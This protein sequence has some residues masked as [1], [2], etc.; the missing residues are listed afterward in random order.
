MG[1][2]INKITRFLRDLDWR[3]RGEVALLILK[4]QA[5]YAPE[6]RDQ[7]MDDSNIYID[8]L[9]FPHFT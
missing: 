4:T 5:E 7:N 8:K 9:I 2:N 1:L 3:R 6:S